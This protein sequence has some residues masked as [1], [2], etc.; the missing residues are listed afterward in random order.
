MRPISV[1]PKLDAMRP[2]SKQRRERVRPRPNDL[3]SRPHGP[4]GLNIPDEHDIVYMYITHFIFSLV[5]NSNLNSPMIV[6]QKWTQLEHSRPKSI[7]KLPLLSLAYMFNRGGRPNL[8][9]IIAAQKAQS[10]QR[11]VTEAR[12]NLCTQYPCSGKSTLHFYR[13]WGDWL[14]IRVHELYM[15]PHTLL[16]QIF[17]PYFN[18]FLF[19]S[20]VLCS[21]DTQ[22][23]NPSNPGFCPH[24]NPCLWVW[25]SAGLPGFS[26]T[27]VAFPMCSV[28]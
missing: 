11:S 18:S 5:S 14:Q 16:F 4:P 6:V 28:E 21:T 3:A 13:C 2:R 12:T 8:L 10:I 1:R 26:G 22:N 25:K 20:A 24:T 19:M 9:A 15:R 27:Q 23:L 7:D 17:L